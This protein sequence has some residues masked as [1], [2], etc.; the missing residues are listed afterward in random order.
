MYIVGRQ[1]IYIYYNQ[2]FTT[3]SCP[4][5]VNSYT[6]ELISLSPVLPELETTRKSRPSTLKKAAAVAPILDR[7]WSGTNAP[8]HSNRAEFPVSELLARKRYWLL[9]LEKWYHFSADVVS[10]NCVIVNDRLSPEWIF[11]ID[12]FTYCMDTAYQM[13]K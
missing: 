10:R 5:L 9:P 4:L 11:Q 12:K 7:V 1:E 8:L 2:S 6:V 13:G 3:S